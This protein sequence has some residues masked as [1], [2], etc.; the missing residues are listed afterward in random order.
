[1]AVLPTDEES[2]ILLTYY[3]DRVK[4]L[5]NAIRKHRDQ[6]SHNQCWEND[7]ELYEVLK[8]DGDN[9]GPHRTLPCR[10]EFMKRCHA[11][12]ESRLTELKFQKNED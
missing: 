12:Y 6:T 2:K 4:E 5:E 1:M 8:D 10:E 7:L 9:L 3:K 11:Y